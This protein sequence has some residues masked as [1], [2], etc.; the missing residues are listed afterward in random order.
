MTHHPKTSDDFITR[1]NRIKLIVLDVDGVMTDGVIAF[2][3]NGHEHKH[4]HVRDG[5]AIAGWLRSGRL[6]AILSGRYA[7][8]VEHRAKDLKIP[9]VIQGN[10]RKIN[11][12]LGIRQQTGLSLDQTCFMGDDLPDLPLFHMVGLAA[13]PADGVEEIQAKAH[14]VSQ[15]R[16]GHGAVH[17]LVSHLMKTQGIWSDHVQWYESQEHS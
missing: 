13:S 1:A 14:F 11:G 7:R 12:L 10:P 8:C 15:N 17:D 4:F 16:G 3:D 2:D 5:S 9:I 6:I